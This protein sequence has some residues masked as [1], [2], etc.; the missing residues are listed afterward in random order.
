MKTILMTLLLATTMTLGAQ[1]RVTTLYTIDDAGQLHVGDNAFTENV[2]EQ[3]SPSMTIIPVDT[4][5]VQNGAAQYQVVVR[6]YG[7]YGW[8]RITQNSLFNEI[9]V[10]NSE[11]QE[12]LTY[13]NV[14]AWQCTIPTYQSSSPQTNRYAQIFPMDNG[15]TV[16]FLTGWHYDVTLPY[17]TMIVLYRDEAHV[18]YNVP[19]QLEQYGPVQVS[20]GGYFNIS[21]LDRQLTGQ[22][23]AS[24][25]ANRFSMTSDR[26]GMYLDATGDYLYARDGQL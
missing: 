11:G 2:L 9:T 15:S 7:G 19:E 22:M 20:A 25:R 3:P 5:R 1:E 16:L 12:L 23:D 13:R 4:F 10:Y 6:L 21:Y 8:N 14:D 24:F 17:I 26:Q 18:V